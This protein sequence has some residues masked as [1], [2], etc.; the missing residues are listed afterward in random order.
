MSADGFEQQ[1]DTTPRNDV[2]LLPE[3]AESR[4]AEQMLDHVRQETD[5]PMPSHADL[6]DRGRTPG[7]TVDRLSGE[8]VGRIIV[9]PRGNGMIEPVGGS[10][11]ARGRD[12]RDT[13]T[14]RADGSVFQRLDSFPRPHGHQHEPPVPGQG[15]KY[16]NQGPSLDTSGNV[17]PSNSKEAH[18]DVR[19]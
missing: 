1:P 15:G 14:L 3:R 19:T 6:A 18:W 13:H 4:A 12:G 11:V 7:P 16:P 9:D 10:T 8:E 5:Q 17:V 2:P